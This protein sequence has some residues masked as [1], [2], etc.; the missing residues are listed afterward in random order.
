MKYTFKTVNLTKSLPPYSHFIPQHKS[1][2]WFYVVF[3]WNPDSSQEPIRHSGLW[4]CPTSL[5]CYDFW[6]TILGHN[7]LFCRPL[8]ISISFLPQDLCMALLPAWC[9][10]SLGC[11]MT[12]P[13]SPSEPLF[14]R[15]SRLG[16]CNPH[17][18]SHPPVTPLPV[19]CF[20]FSL[21][22][23]YIFT[24]YLLATRLQSSWKQGLG[25]FVQHSVSNTRT[26]PDV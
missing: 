7:I 25:Y 5:V 2:Q 19:P 14:G 10:L 3:K 6:L 1:L 11:A 17:S 24:I 22:T 15:P 18:H 16:L 20:I 23:C 26:V 8:N 9:T 21:F 12:G 4:L 13:S